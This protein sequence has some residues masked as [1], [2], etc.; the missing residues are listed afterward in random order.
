MLIKEPWLLSQVH[1][2]CHGRIYRQLTESQV[3]TPGEWRLMRTV[4]VRM[5][6][7]MRYFGAY[8]ARKLTVTSPISSA[9]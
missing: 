9:R 6:V 4:L 8:Q 2:L 7:N 5:S 1:E 3:L